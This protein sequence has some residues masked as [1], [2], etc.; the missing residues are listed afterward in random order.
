MRRKRIMTTKEFS[1]VWNISEKT[2][3]KWCKTGMIEGAYKDTKKHWIIPDGSVRPLKEIEIRQVLLA[4]ILYKNGSCRFDCTHLG[5]P[6]GKNQNLLL[7]LREKSFIT[8]D[9][10]EEIDIALQKICIT[11]AGFKILSFYNVDS[12]NIPKALITGAL[13]ICGMLFL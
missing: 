12:V 3:R 9:I 8:G 4:I 11:N 2:V 5:I 7:Y 10:S 6:L 1:R 13:K